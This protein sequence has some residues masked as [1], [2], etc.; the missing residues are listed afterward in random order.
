MNLLLR[1]AQALRLFVPPS[2]NAPKAQ[3]Q[4]SGERR[5]A[6]DESAA[7]NQRER[8]W[9]LGYAPAFDRLMPFETL[10]QALRQAQEGLQG[11]RETDMSKSATLNRQPLE[12]QGERFARRSEIL[13]RSA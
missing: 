13:V 4:S 11:E 8:N 10:R 5:A 7:E 2:A 12:A 9:T 1:Y 6:S 3:A